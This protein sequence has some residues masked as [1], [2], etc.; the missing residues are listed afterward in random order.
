MS[1]HLRHFKEE[2][3][4][5][6]KNAKT[7]KD[8]AD[9]ALQ[10]INRIPEGVS[11]IS[12][13]ISTGGVGNTAE[14]LTVFSNVTEILI[15]ENEINVLSWIPFETKMHEF[16][17]EWKKTSKDG[18]YCMPILEDFYQP[19]FSSGKVNDVHF[20][21]GWESSFGSR[22]EHNLCEKLGIKKIYLSPKLSQKA[23][24]RGG[25]K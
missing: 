3:K 23:L 16:Y 1:I 9:L 24:K 7:F 6:L 5:H 11:A 8:L 14:N 19:I 15:E 20:I 18:E 17:L 2:E 22:W 10:I 25:K 13:P 12:G 4:E 21:H